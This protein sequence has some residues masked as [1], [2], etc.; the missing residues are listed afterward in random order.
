MGLIS[1]GIAR[2]GAVIFGSCGEQLHRTNQQVQCVYV[3][4]FIMQTKCLRDSRTQASGFCYLLWNIDLMCVHHVRIVTV[5]VIIGN[6][7]R[8]T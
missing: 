5:G 6:I 8:V 3:F 1:F 2:G 7:E 4:L